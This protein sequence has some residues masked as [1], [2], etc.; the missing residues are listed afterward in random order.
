MEANNE[1]KKEVSTTPKRLSR[2]VYLRSSVTYVL[3]KYFGLL[4]GNFNLQKGPFWIIKSI[5]DQ[6][7][8]NFRS[9]FL[10]QKGHILDRKIYF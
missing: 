2:K 7:K 10:I 8:S 4:K 1:N 9:E 6:K 5:L 3:K